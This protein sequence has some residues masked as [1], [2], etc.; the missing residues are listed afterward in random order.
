MHPVSSAHVP[1]QNELP[2]NASFALCTLNNVRKAAEATGLVQP[3]PVVEVIRKVVSP[4]SCDTPIV[5]IN[6]PVRVTRLAPC[7]DLMERED[8]ITLWADE[9]LA[10]LV[11]LLVLGHLVR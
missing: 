1:G 11:K 8:A 5:L 3:P 6:G 4:F 9:H 2:L 7:I 10:E